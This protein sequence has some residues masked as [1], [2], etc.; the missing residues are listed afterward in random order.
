METSDNSTGDALIGFIYGVFFDCRVHFDGTV[1][2]IIV[3]TFYKLGNLF[4]S[5]TEF[6]KLMLSK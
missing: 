4:S 3:L 1:E 2:I 6:K 5:N